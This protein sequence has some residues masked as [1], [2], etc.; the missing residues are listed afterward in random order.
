MRLVASGDEHGFDCDKAA[1][2]VRIENG[3]SEIWVMSPERAIEIASDDE[4]SRWGT[5][6]RKGFLPMLDKQE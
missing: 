1:F 4:E 3:A 2:P 6:F 5:A